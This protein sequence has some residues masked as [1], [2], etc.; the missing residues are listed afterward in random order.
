MKTSQNKKYLKR[1]KSIQYGLHTDSAIN[2]EKLS[3]LYNAIDK[4]DDQ[5]VII[6]ALLVIT[7]TEID[8]ITDFLNKFSLFSEQVR[9]L[10]IPMLACTDYVECYDFLFEYLQKFP[11]SN[12]AIVIVYTLSTTHYYGILPMILARLI[13]DD[14]AFLAHLKNI[15]FKMGLKKL[16]PF[17]TMLPQIPHEAV[18]RELFGDEKID[19]IKSLR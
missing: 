19:H 5:D 2:E 12:E 15:L 8:V 10:A 7:E 16:S 14:D 18:F 6:A 11:K 3:Y 17:L 4:S 9:L 1:I 13:T